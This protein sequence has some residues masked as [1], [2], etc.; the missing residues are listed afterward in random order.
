MVERTVHANGIEIWTEDFGDAED[1]T[2]LLIMGATAQ[3]IAWPDAYA[4]RE[5]QKLRASTISLWSFFWSRALRAE[6]DR[7]R[8]FTASSRNP[9]YGDALMIERIQEDWLCTG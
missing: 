9:T 6:A 2:V 8:I 4:G 1:P 3:G 7:S 5:T